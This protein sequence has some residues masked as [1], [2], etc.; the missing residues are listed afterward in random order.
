MKTMWQ[1]LRDA[2]SPPSWSLDFSVSAPKSKKRG[3]SESNSKRTR[4]RKQL[5]EIAELI[6]RV[7]PEKEQIWR[8]AQ[9][10]QHNVGLDKYDMEC[11]SKNGSVVHLR[12]TGPSSLKPAEV[13][14]SCRI[15]EKKGKRSEVTTH[16]LQVK[17]RDNEFFSLL[18]VAAKRP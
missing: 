6:V 2:V 4:E 3:P 18:A 12:Y 1:R 14:L 16:E 8:A 15:V 9:N 5:Q 11:K 17:D 10:L 7:A 13:R